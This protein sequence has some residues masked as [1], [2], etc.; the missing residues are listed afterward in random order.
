VLTYYL[1]DMKNILLVLFLIASNY[2]AFGQEK[3][4]N[5]YEFIIVPERFAFL[6]QNNQYQTSS[7]TKFLLE[8]NGFTIFLDSEEYPRAL[9]DNPCNGLT[10]FV[11]DKSSMF[12]T[13]VSIELKDCFNKVV[14]T[15]EEGGSKLKDYKKGFQE[16]IRN[17]HASMSDVTYK[18]LSIAP[19]AEAKKEIA[20]EV[21][22]MQQTV[23]TIEVV[24][25]KAVA[26]ILVKTEK[27]ALNKKKESINILYA[28]PKENGFQLINSKPTVVFVIL[29]TNVKDVFIL[30]GKNGILYKKE[31]IWV[32]E[33]YE[34]GAFIEEKY[35]VKF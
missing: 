30:K 17:A 33:F 4:I 24:A 25:E 12:K 9:K 2:V 18:A 6:K 34:N 10:A 11:V 31:S 14:Y 7:L 29:Q 8:K 32:A 15:S 26:T 22:V 3:E 19:K 35:Q 20:V 21:P 16:A 5:N 23:K 28:Q 27:R 13:K 1:I